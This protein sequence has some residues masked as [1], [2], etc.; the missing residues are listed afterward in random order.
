MARGWNSIHPLMA[1]ALQQLGIPE[2]AVTQGW[3]YAK[4]SASYHSPEGRTAKYPDGHP[5]SS[6]VDLSW[7]LAEPALQDRLI[8]AGFCPFFRHTG[9]FADNRHIHCVY[10]GARDYRG[11]ATI[12][13]GPRMQIVDFT[14]GLDGLVGHNS[15]REPWRPTPG[16][17]AEVAAQYAAWVPDVATRVLSPEGEWVRCYAFLER[18]VVRCELRAFLLWAGA[19]V[20]WDGR[21]VH[22]SLGGQ[23][24][25]LTGCRLRVEGAFTRG[26]LRPLAEACGFALTFTAEGAAARVQLHYR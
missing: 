13:P 26:D 12:L 1:E 11:K 2:E 25:D 10:V 19:L 21:Q 17:C 9:S 5:F 14:R 23:P 3:G 24:L 16:Q 8:A 22:A 6:C 15:L 4:A 20:T 7:R 18:D